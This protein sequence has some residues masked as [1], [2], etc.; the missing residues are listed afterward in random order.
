MLSTWS[1]LPAALWKTKDGHK[2]D[3]WPET[4]WKTAPNKQ[5]SIVQAYSR[6]PHVLSTYCASNNLFACFTISVSLWN[7]FFK[8]DKHWNLLGTEIS[9]CRTCQAGQTLEGRNDHLL[10]LQLS[11]EGW[12]SKPPTRW[13]LFSV[14][15]LFYLYINEKYCACKGQT[16]EAEPWEWAIICV[17][18]CRQQHSTMVQ[19]QHD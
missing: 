11:L 5:P 17:S 6:F 4:T 2:R 9:C 15:H 13:T 8:E 7:S 3:V 10:F 16:W 19:S 12:S 1:W 14:V 18:G